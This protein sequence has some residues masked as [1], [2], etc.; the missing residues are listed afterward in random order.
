MKGIPSPPKIML[1][2]RIAHNIILMIL[3]IL[4]MSVVGYF[5]YN[6]SGRFFLACPLK[7]IT[8]L[9]CPGCGS[10]RAFHELLH[11]NFQKA[12]RYNSL[13]VLAIPYAALGIFLNFGNNKKKYEKL[14]SI[15]YAKAAVWIIVLCI[16]L[17]FIFR[18][19]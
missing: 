15:L 12:F 5:Y 18:N 9:D 14:S 2:K 16:F 6:Q 1:R 4:M 17:F 11:L 10:Q 19:L 3:I 13:F 8:S 7:K